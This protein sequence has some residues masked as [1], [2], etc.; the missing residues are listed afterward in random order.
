VAS[1]PSETP[2]FA[3]LTGQVLDGRYRMVEKV[4]EGGMCL[5]YHAQDTLSGD[6]VAVKILLPALIN[7]PICMAR[8]RREAALGR[9]LAHP[10][11]CHIIRL[12]EITAGF[13]YI[14]MPFVEGVLLRERIILAGQ[15]SLHVTASFLRDMC[16]GLHVAH[17]LGILHRDLKPENIMVVTRPD[18]SEHAVVI[19]FSL[20]NGPEV[21]QLTAP[22]LVV[23]TPEFMSPEQLRGQSLDQRSDIYSL[24][25]MV[26]EMLTGQ[27]PFEGRT[28]HDLMIARL[29]GDSIPIRQ[30]RPDLEFSEAI[31]QVMQKALAHDPGQRYATAPKFSD[32]FTQ[33]AGPDPAGGRRGGILDRLLR[34]SA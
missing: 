28:Q 30:R 34:R 15:L 27:L 22:G 33:A 12:G 18:G 21:Q 9:K 24:A 13:D 26:Y 16:S 6:K 5:V 20:A 7:D 1:T 17:S 29:K 3:D 8:L 19:D 14:V 2:D 4:G 23:G 31:E 25:F 10:N 11:V 32:A